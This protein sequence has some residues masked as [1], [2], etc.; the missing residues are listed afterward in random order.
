MSSLEVL[1][2]IHYFKQMQHRY[3]FLH[4]VSMSNYYF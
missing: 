3:S 2:A 1:D 4:N